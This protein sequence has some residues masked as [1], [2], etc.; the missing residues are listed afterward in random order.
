M[1]EWSTD[2]LESLFRKE[3]SETEKSTDSVHESGQRPRASG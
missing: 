3:D 1:L 2:H